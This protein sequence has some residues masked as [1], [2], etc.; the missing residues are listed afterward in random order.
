[1]M[2]TGAIVRQLASISILFLMMLVVNF[3]AVTNQ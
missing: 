2:L 3:T 1:M